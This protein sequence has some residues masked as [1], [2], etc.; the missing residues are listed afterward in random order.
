L[1]EE[2]LRRERARIS[3]FI[4]NAEHEEEWSLQGALDV[5]ACEEAMFAADSRVAKLPAQAGARYLM[6]QKLRKDA[7]R[8]ARGWAQEA[9]TELSRAL[10]GLVLA[11][12]SLRPPP[13]SPDEPA[14]EGAFHWALLVPRGAEAELARRLEPLAEQLSARGLHLSARGPWPAYNFA[15]HFGDSPGNEGEVR[16]HG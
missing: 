8:A 4:E 10:E 3:A 9:Q 6:E 12:R 13:R 15:P 11:R 2:L 16:T 14:L 1:L 7:A 5:R